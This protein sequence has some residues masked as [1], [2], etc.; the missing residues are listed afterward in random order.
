MSSDKDHAATPASG[1][2]PTSGSYDAETNAVT[3]VGEWDFSSKDELRALTEKLRPNY[4]TIDLTNATFI[5]SSVINEIVR[6]FNRLRESDGRMRLFVGE[7][8]IAR[9]FGIAGLDK[10]IDI[11]R[12]G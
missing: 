3:L 4:A 10:L 8:H 2:E 1:L 12:K 9:L 6:T 11:E 7:G 5:D